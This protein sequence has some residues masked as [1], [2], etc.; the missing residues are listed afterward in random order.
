VTIWSRLFSTQAAAAGVQRLYLATNLAARRRAS[1]ASGA[2]V[3]EDCPEVPLR[4]CLGVDGDLDGDI[5]THMK[6]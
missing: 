3:V 1:A 2:D 4:I 5:P 6:P